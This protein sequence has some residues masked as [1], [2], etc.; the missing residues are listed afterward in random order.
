MSE[1]I[2]RLTKFGIDV[3]D[4]DRAA[5]FWSQVL[6][7]EPGERRGPY[8]SLGSL[9]PTT[10]FFLQLVPEEKRVKNRMH[11]DISVNDLDKAVRRVVALGGTMLREVGDTDNHLCVM[12]DPDGNE[13]CLLPPGW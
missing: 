3:G 6:G 5:A 9:T 2:G 11:F 10:I 4:L 13:F 8:Q 7:L 1:P 12:A